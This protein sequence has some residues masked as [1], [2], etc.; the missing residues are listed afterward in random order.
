M[1]HRSTRRPVF[2]DIAPH[3]D[4]GSAQGCRDNGAVVLDHHV[5]AKELVESFGK[6]GIYADAEKEPG[7]SG[8]VLARREVWDAVAEEYG[9]TGKF[10]VHGFAECVGARDT[11]Q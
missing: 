11:W 7:V 2:C 8:A 3:P 4:Y 1:G 5:G 6:N 10:A 9:T